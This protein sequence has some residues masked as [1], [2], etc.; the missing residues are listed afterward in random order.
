VGGGGERVNHK[1]SQ[2]RRGEYRADL[3]AIPICGKY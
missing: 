3:V 1:D 2:R